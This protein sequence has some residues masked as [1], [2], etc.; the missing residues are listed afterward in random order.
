MSASD[1]ADAIAVSNASIV[2]GRRCGTC[3]MCCKVM[4]VAEIA[5]PL[6]QWCPHCAR[7]KGCKIYDTRPG[8]CRAFLCGWLTWA[9]LGPEWK[10]EHSK[11]VVYRDQKDGRF[12]VVNVDPGFPLAWR[13][14]AVYNRLKQWAIAWRATPSQEMK[15][16]V[17]VRIA[18]RV[19]VILPD[20]DVDV[21]IIAD[22]E[23]LLTSEKVGPRGVDV[24]V[25]KVKRGQAAAASTA[26]TSAS[27]TGSA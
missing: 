14:P 17:T 21:G 22:D 26:T 7:G 25:H 16:L 19:V 9:E 27:S 8:E 1:P 20:R 15:L 18:R 3:T 24:E 12:L 5:K 23:V 11:V 2:P 6:D 10:P 4:G 13:S